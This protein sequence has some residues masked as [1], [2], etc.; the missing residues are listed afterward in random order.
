MPLLNLDLA[1][2][3]FQAITKRAWDWCFLDWL[4]LPKE[5]LKLSITGLAV[6][7]SE[8]NIFSLF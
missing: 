5:V 4:T 2:G 8:S 7:L 1:D 3:L 6:E